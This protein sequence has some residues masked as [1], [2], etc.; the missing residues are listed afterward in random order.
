MS[1]GQLRIES[2]GKWL[3]THETA[4]QPLVPRP[5]FRR[6]LSSPMAGIPDS[7]SSSQGSRSEREGASRPPPVEST[8]HGAEPPLPDHHFWRIRSIAKRPP[9]Q[10]QPSDL[11]LVLPRPERVIDIGEESK[12]EPGGS[13]LGGLGASLARSL[14]MSLSS[15]SQR[16]KVDERERQPVMLDEAICRICFDQLTEGET[17]RLECQC[18]GDM[19]LAHEQCALRWF[20]L[21][22]NRLC[23]VCGSEVEN[24]PVILERR[25]EGENGTTDG[26]GAATAGAAAADE[27]VL[28]RRYR[29]VPMVFIA[30]AVAYFCF[31][32]QM[33]VSQQGK[34]AVSVSIPASLILAVTTITIAARTDPSKLWGLGLMQFFF[35]VIVAQ[36]TFSLGHVGGVGACFIGGFV[37]TVGTIVVYS[38]IRDMRRYHSR[39]REPLDVPHGMGIAANQGE[40][41]V[42]RGID[43]P[44][45]LRSDPVDTAAGDSDSHRSRQSNQPPA[46]SGGGLEEVR[47]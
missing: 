6:Q 20:N 22:G 5:S 29:D 7:P 46:S 35:V 42:E 32:E 43:S 26:S 13:V 1:E 34:D 23:E 36:L 38:V 12:R 31:F 44:D 27:T 24:L 40:E 25:R 11:V 19:A 47:P 17:W 41:M 9:L 2:S 18:K 15:L 28:P 8:V 10:R 30:A 39:T 33:L 21:R 37:G 3:G 45:Q 14:S 16:G 4:T